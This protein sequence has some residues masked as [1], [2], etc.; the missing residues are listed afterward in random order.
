[1]R[2]QRNRVSIPP[3][4][5]WRAAKHGVWRDA[6]RIVWPAG[7]VVALLVSS[8][9]ARAL[10]EDRWGW[11]YCS[12]PYPPTCVEHLGPKKT[13]DEACAKQ[14][15]LYITSVFAYRE[16]QSRELERAILEANHVSGI[17]KCRSDKS[18]CE[19]RK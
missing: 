15:Q 19:L 1:M 9:A 18:F 8:S 11:N 13:S 16:C 10:N 14:V 2:D 5:D 17:M 6:R 4:K 12:P 7:L 3:V